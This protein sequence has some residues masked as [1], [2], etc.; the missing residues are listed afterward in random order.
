MKTKVQ[1]NTKVQLNTQ[2]KPKA[3]DNVK[4]KV[5]TKTSDTVHEGAILEME[6]WAAKKRRIS[7]YWD[8]DQEWYSGTITEFINITRSHKI[9]YDDGDTET[10][11]LIGWI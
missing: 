4:T 7:V 1:S 10:L 11:Y 2:V 6:S 9:V 5:K 3:E 8:E